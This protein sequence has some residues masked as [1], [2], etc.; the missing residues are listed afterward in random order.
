MT[1]NG[2]QKPT[3][4]E[5]QVLKLIAKGLRDREIATKLRLSYKTIQAHH[6]SLNRRLNVHSTS[7]L[8][9][10]ALQSGVL[11]SQELTA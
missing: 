2:H 4:R 7:Q 8:I 3:D 11:T 6:A 10:A 5:M 1:R 9:R